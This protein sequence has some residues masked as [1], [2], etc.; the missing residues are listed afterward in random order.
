MIAHLEHAPQLLTVIVMLL[1][2]CTRM[3]MLN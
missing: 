3:Q 2:I 1:Q